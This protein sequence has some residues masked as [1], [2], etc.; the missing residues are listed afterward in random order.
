MEFHRQSSGEQTSTITWKEVASLVPG[1]S[2]TRC[3]DRWQYYIVPS[4]VKGPF[5]REEDEV[6][7][8]MVAEHRQLHGPQ[9]PIPWTRLCADRL[10]DRTAAAVK[11]RHRHL[12][13]KQK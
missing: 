3:R 11:T 13:T 7:L 12:S 5:S 6:I 2:D 9:V 1:R 10:P 8:R 4:V